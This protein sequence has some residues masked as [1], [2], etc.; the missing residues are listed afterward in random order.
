MKFYL[1]CNLGFR[2]SKWQDHTSFVLL[3]WY[4]FCSY[5][6]EKYFPPSRVLSRTIASVSISISIN[7]FSEIGYLPFH[8]VLHRWR[9]YMFSTF[10]IYIFL[11]FLINIHEIH[12]YIIYISI[13]IYPRIKVALILSDGRRIDFTECSQTFSIEEVKNQRKKWKALGVGFTHTQSRLWL[14][15]RDDLIRI[16]LWGP[17]Q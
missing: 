9:E 16:C 14:A 10:Y 11:F 7:L 8:V 1:I 2:I 17:W 6:K 4:F 5:K 15:L 3:T 13:N 12:N